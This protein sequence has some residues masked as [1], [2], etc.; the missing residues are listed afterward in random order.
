MIY[1]NVK[2]KKKKA[3]KK[4]RKRKR[5]K[6]KKKH[7]RKKIITFVVALALNY[8]R[9]VNVG[10]VTVRMKCQTVVTHACFSV[11]LRAMDSMTFA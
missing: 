4:K 8:G 2:K 6:K 1:W 11:R 3:R 7:T 9:I 10:V 5:K